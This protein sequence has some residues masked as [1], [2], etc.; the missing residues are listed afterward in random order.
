MPPDRQWRQGGWGAYLPDLQVPGELEP[1]CL[2]RLPPTM[3]VYLVEPKL[4]CNLVGFWSVEENC[5]TYLAQPARQVIQAWWVGPSQEV[6][7]CQGWV[8]SSAFLTS[9]YMGRLPVPA[10]VGRRGHCRAG[11]MPA[12]CLQNLCC[13]NRQQVNCPCLPGG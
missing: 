8:G 10:R 11:T 7:A 1:A 3:P 4:P 2:P 13:P 5:P 9:L 6:P 12:C